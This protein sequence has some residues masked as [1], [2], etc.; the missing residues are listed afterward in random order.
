MINPT[1]ADI[2]RRVV[3]VGNR[4]PGGKLERGV[5]TGVNPRAVFVRYDSEVHSKATS[6]E[7]LEWDDPIRPR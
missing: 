2:G 4:Y 5:I 1:D 3:Y 7:D 6:R